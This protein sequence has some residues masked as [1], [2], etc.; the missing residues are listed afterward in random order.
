MTPI[1]FLFCYGGGLKDRAFSTCH[2]ETTS[3][4]SS[5][6]ATWCCQ[7]SGQRQSCMVSGCSKPFPESESAFI[8]DYSALALSVLRL[9]PPLA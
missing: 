8:D 7:I 2:R 1:S 9:A 6:T 5:V 3:F 4:A